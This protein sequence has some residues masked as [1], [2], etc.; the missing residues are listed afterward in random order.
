V[1]AMVILGREECIKRLE[2]A[3][4]LLSDV[5]TFPFYTWPTACKISCCLEFM[6]LCR[7]EI[8]HVAD[9]RTFAAD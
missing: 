2:A 6:N 8:S 4:D 1:E 5:S 3:A 9:P 7:I